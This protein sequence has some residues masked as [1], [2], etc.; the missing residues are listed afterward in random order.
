MSKNQCLLFMHDGVGSTGP[1][2]SDV[3]AQPVSPFTQ[4]LWGLQLCLCSSVPS[5]TK[6]DD[7]S[8]IPRSHKDRKSISPSNLQV[9]G[10]ADDSR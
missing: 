8:F 4:E 7:V 2:A 9:Q 5:P 1:G 6:G 3:W 10:W